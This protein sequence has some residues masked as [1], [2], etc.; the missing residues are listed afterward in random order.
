M[1]TPTQFVPLTYADFYLVY[2]HQTYSEF[3]DNGE[4]SCHRWRV[5]ACRWQ[6][7]SHGRCKTRSATNGCRLSAVIA[8]ADM[9]SASSA[10][11]KFHIYTSLP[12]EVWSVREVH[13]IAWRLSNNQEVISEKTCCFNLL[14]I[15]RKQLGRH[16]SPINPMKMHSCNLLCFE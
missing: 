1:W 14:D 13:G 15:S 7:L 3:S 10:A 2:S 12:A 11:V 8:N 6:I 9:S 4:T 5:Y 16:F